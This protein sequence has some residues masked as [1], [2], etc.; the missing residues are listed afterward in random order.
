MPHKNKTGRAANGSGSIRKREVT[1]NG[2]P[3]TYWEGRITVDIDP[4]TGKQVQ[5]TITGKTQ[6]EVAQKMREIAV[7]VD[8]KTYKAPC[9]L[10]LGEWLDIW[11]AE[12][13]GDVKPSTAYLYGR[14]I[15]QYIIPYLGAVK[16]E[17]LTPLQVQEFYNRLLKPDKEEARPLSAKTVR[18]VHGVL[19]KALEQAVQVGYIRSNPANACKPP[20]AAKAEIRPLDADQVSAFLKSLQGHPHEY[21]YQVTMFT[22]L[23][24]GEVLGLTWDCLDMERGTLLVKQQLRREQKKGGKYYFSLTKNNKIRVLTLAPS[25]VRLF[26]LQKIRQNGMRAKAGELWQETNLIFTNEMGDRLSYRTVYDCFKRVMVKIGAPS[27][28]FHDLRHTYAVMAIQSGDDIKTVQENL[29]HATAAFT[30]D[31]YGHVTAQMKQASA[32]R[33]EKFIQ[34][35]SA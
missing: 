27:T 17:K 10:T 25:V 24:Q 32:D 8:Q 33:M 19:H 20:R 11:K 12:Y 35:V 31:V 14:N 2:K 29:G 1:R 26:R 28:R 9:K 22:G 30:L 4:I 15:D 23:R 3:Y 16:L 34:S 6:K 18:N 13:T 21:L 5:R 7:E